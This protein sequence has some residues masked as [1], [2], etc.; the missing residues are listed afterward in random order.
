MVLNYLGGCFYMDFDNIMCL[1][2]SDVL[3]LLCFGGNVCE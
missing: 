3:L 1:G 2:V